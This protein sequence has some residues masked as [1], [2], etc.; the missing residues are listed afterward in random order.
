MGYEKDETAGS[1]PRYRIDGGN[2]DR[3][4]DLEELPDAH[5]ANQGAGSVHH[6]AFAVEDRAAQLK[7][8]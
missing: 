7:M 2:A 1:V 6:I 5:H 8:R 4:V 3:T